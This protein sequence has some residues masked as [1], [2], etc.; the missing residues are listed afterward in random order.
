MKFTYR[1]NNT[2][3]LKLGIESDEE[4]TG[5]AFIYYY[6]YDNYAYDS[7]HKSLDDAFESAR[8]RFNLLKEDW[9]I[10]EEKEEP[11]SE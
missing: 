9:E 7:W 8:E 11:F 6:T 4:D 5:G 10:E 1:I 3:Y 2:E